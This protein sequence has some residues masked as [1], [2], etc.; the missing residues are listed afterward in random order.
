VADVAVWRELLSGLHL[1][2]GLQFSTKTAF[3]ASFYQI[4]PE[5]PPLR[6]IIESSN[7]SRNAC[8]RCGDGASY[9]A[10]E[11]HFL[12]RSVVVPSFLAI[13]LLDTF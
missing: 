7:S 2:G 3:Q 9:V 11:I 8:Q 13:S 6:R 12:M 1:Y 10:N 4:S 5:R